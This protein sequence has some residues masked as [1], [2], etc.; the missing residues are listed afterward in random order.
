M[1]KQLTKGLFWAFVLLLFL[2]LAF[3]ARAEA[4][5]ISY[6]DK[7]DQWI[8]NLGNC[9]SGN[10]PHKI[11]PKDTDGTP[12]LGRFQYKVGTFIEMNKK[13]NVFPDEKI[14]KLMAR[15][16][17]YEDSEKMTRT[18][19]ENDY[20]AYKRWPGCTYGNAKNKAGL[21]PVKES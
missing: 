8:L 15:I 19:I 9:E 20:N 18:I 17:D 5:E 21:P 3:I 2:A 13:Y 11:N 10:N 14:D 16:M 1:N 12:S 4:P 7:F 6:Q